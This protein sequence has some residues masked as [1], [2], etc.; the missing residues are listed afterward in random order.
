MSLP[1]SFSS[2]PTALPAP[3]P[4][5]PAL[6]G[7]VSTFP[8][9]S[10]IPLIQPP[11][12][13]G[14]NSC[15][16]GPPQPSVPHVVIVFCHSPGDIQPEDVPL[17]TLL[18]EPCPPALA[19]RMPAIHCCS[20]PAICCPPLPLE[21]T[22]PVLMLVPGTLSQQK[23]LLLSVCPPCHARAVLPPWPFPPALQPLLAL[24][25][26]GVWRV[27]HLH[28]P[29]SCSLVTLTKLVPSLTSV[30]YTCHQVSGL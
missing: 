3:S 23:P 11:Y 25:L 10:L 27:P 15:F 22:V 18:P 21:S 5:S 7:P 19:P 1:S 4:P 26:A 13:A 12:V 20:T 16:T 9:P 14:S 28:S 17:L 6:S 24:A 8:P 30:S 2:G 29:P